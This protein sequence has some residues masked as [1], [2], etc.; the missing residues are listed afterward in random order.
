MYLQPRTIQEACLSLAEAP[1]AILAGGTDVYPALGDRRPHNRVL[2]VS[3]VADLRGVARD[4]QHVRIGAGTTWTDLIAADLPACFDG[5][6]AAA[7]EVGSVQ[8]QNLGTIGGNLCNASPAADGVPP[9]LT[10]DAE[11]ELASQAGRRRLPVAEFLLGN[12][13]TRLRPDEILTAILVP[14]AFERGRSIFLKL[15]GRRYLVIS[16][17]MVSAVVE[18]AP[19]G[20]VRLARVAIGSCSAVA[21]RLPGLEADLLGAEATPGLGRLVTADHL[22]TLSPID[23][24][25]ASA[26]YRVEAALELTRRALD[27]CVVS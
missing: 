15:G 18:L 7:R 12:R 23:D 17:V 19:D 21:Q 26:A 4:D 13:R 8:I 10:L 16:V 22:A 14:R 5:L 25:R 1:A 2:D 6:K 11:V 27:G 20:R 3:R 24:L 9:L